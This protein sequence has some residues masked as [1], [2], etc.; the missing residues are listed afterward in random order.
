MSLW[1]CNQPQV[2]VG[3]EVEVDS[4]TEQ[5]I[6]HESPEEVDDTFEEQP[7]CQHVRGFEVIEAARAG[8]CRSRAVAS[9]S[10]N[11]GI[12]Q[13]AGSNRHALLL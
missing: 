11:R 5:I 8:V 2:A 9:L 3:A 10:Q 12:R 13:R 7:S 6:D 1:F 4:Q